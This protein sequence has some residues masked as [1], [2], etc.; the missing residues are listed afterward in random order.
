MAAANYTPLRIEKIDGCDHGRQQFRLLEP[1][2]FTV[3]LN[4]GSITL[5]VPAGYVTDFASV[6]RLFWRVFPPAGQ[7]CEASVTHDWLCQL[8]GCSRFLAD[9]MFREAMFRL[10]VPVWRRVLMYYAVRFYGAFL[11]RRAAN[12]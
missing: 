10:G 2:T 4:G 11:A 3:G 1:L 8:P 6:P 5:T 7:Y 9:A 12:A